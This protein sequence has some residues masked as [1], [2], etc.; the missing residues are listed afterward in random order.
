MLFKKLLILS[1]A[2]ALIF[3]MACSEDSSTEP[4]PKVNEFKLLADVGDDYFTTY[5]TAGG[6]D[7]NLGM[8]ALFPLLTDMDTGNDP[9]IID[10]RSAADYNYKHIIGAVNMPLA[11]LITAV[12]AGTIPMDK[13]IVN[14]CYTGQT[15]SVA[16]A[17]LN[18]LGYE[19]QNLSFGMCGVTTDTNVVKKTTTWVS[20]TAADE[21]T[22]NKVAVPAPTTEYTLPTLST[23]AK[24]ADDVIKE[25]F[26]AALTWSVSFNNVIANPTD[27]FIVN[28]W[29]ATDYNDIGHID[30]A[31]QFTPKESLEQ[32]QMLKYLPTN[33]KI[34]VYCW[35]GQTSAQVVPYLRMLGYDAYS[36]TFGVNGFAY[37]QIP[38]GKPRYSAPTSDF[39][40][41][42]E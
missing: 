31:Y 37:F 14:V 18:L 3:F 33:K 12:N 38:A 34:A 40:S 21:Y 15:A 16:T 9:Y 11:D 8:A 5:K 28:Y 10:Y 6:L 13:T 35:T 41:V 1:S 29:A 27:Y 2:L 19:A 7:V 42:L 22:L 26:T 25:R 4:T 24:N 39:S 30:G 32:D 36:L 20:Q 17:V 23:G